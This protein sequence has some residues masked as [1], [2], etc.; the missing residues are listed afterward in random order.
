MKN[1]GFLDSAPMTVQTAAIDGRS[2]D[3]P[4]IASSEIDANSLPFVT[5][6]VPRDEPF[7]PWESLSVFNRNNPWGVGA[8]GLPG[9]TPYS[10]IECELDRIGNCI[11]RVQGRDGFP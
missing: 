5:G 9:E 1:R 7:F 3:H 4:M 8:R 11:F 10:K 2:Q 6:G